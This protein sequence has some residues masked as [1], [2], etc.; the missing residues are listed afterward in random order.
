MLAE[1]ELWKLTTICRRLDEGLHWQRSLTRGKTR[2]KES[3]KYNLY[4]LRGIRCFSFTLNKGKWQKAKSLAS[5]H[6]WGAVHYLQLCFPCNGYFKESLNQELLR[7]FHLVATS[8][9]LESTYKM[10]NMLVW[11][12]EAM[13]LEVRKQERAVK[14][15]E[16]SLSLYRPPM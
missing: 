5:V 4:G 15:R 10:R 12:T 3:D 14:E 1:P 6:P 11:G 13:T 9:L 8:P 7:A 16:I 2:N